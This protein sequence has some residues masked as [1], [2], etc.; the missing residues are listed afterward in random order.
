MVSLLARKFIKDYDDY[1]K[2]EVRQ[3][4][5]VLCGT[6]G[7][8]LNII[9]FIIKIIAGIVSGSVA[10]VA[11]AT[12]N[13]GDAGSS[14]I[15]LVGFKMSG[16]KA[17]SDHPFGHGRIE[18]V[19]GFIVSM[20][21]ILM[22]FEL[23]TSSLDKILHPELVEGSAVV[24]GI[25]LVSIAIKIYMYFYN[26]SLSKKLLSQTMKATAM[27]SLTDSIATLVVLIS[28]GVTYFTGF[29]IDG[30]CGMLVALFILYTGITSAK[31]TLDPL[32]G[33]KAD[34]EY[35]ETIEKFV[36]SFDGILG[37]HDMVI[38]DYGPGRVMISLHAEVPATGN[39]IELHDTI[40]NIEKKLND[41]LKCYSVIHMDPVVVDD[42]LTNKMRNISELIAKS[43]DNSLSI[44]DFR[45]VKGPTHTNLIFDVVVPYEVEL[46]EEEVKNYL[47][48]KI[49]RLP[50]RN[51]AVI[52]IDRPLV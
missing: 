51:F 34:P 26:Y 50:G 24:V 37:V 3:G 4:Y 40:D 20:L 30:W 2:T 36:T 10:I 5:G 19:T 33:S 17:D 9:L 28:L 14:I 42:E 52:H 43:I 38:H 35:V 23:A 7:I 47:S 25:L 21:I 12:N 15:M 41:T 8:V 22:G 6:V 16:K 18:Y 45:M 46:T 31:D 44:H 32:L 48:S 29:S 11:D 49:E 27:D 1:N 39:V 13:L